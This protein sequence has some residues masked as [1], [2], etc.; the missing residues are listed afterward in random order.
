MAYCNTIGV[1]YYPI[2]NI[3]RNV[4][5]T[6]AVSLINSRVDTPLCKLR[7]TPAAR[8]LQMCYRLNVYDDMTINM[9]VAGVNIKQQNIIDNHNDIFINV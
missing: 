6:S 1:Q 2:N 8:L 4:S 5:N 9:D 3:F 7:D